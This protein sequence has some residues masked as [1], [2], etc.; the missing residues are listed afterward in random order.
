MLDE[1][2]E[3]KK[4]GL[5]NNIVDLMVDDKIKRLMQRYNGWV[6]GFSMGKRME[7][8]KMKFRHFALEEL[9]LLD[10]IYTNKANG[11]LHPDILD[12]HPYTEEAVLEILNKAKANMP[13]IFFHKYISFDE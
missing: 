11:T 12:N 1:N 7:I 5:A 4:T 10:D 2:L 6:C 8:S 13:R 9:E 3:E